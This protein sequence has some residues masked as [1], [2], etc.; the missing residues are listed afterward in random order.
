MFMQDLRYTLRS[1]WRTPGFTVVALLTLM[2]GLGANTAMFSI[3]NG[4]LLEPLPY[5]DPVRLVS[6]HQANTKQGVR[7]GRVSLPDF[8]DWRQSGA[9]EPMAA[10]DVIPQVLTGS[11]EPIE[12]QA[13][14]ITADFFKVLDVPAQRGRVLNPNDHAARRDQRSAVAGAPLGRSERAGA[15]DPAAG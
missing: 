5:G 8:E 12:M 6:L 7:D 15:S 11:G 10:Y 3:V 9:F 4:I 2:L 1:L 14:Y 13:A